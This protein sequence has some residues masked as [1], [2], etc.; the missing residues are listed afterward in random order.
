M[1]RRRGGTGQDRDKSV[2]TTPC[3]LSPAAGHPRG[4]CGARHHT[5]ATSTSTSISTPI[6]ISISTERDGITASPG[7]SVLPLISRPGHGPELPRVFKIASFGKNEIYLLEPFSSQSVRLADVAPDNLQLHF[8]LLLVS[9]VARELCV[10]TRRGQDPKKERGPK[11]ATNTP[12]S[13]HPPYI[14]TQHTDTS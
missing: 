13:P 4:V 9:H 11:Q 1:S 8:S 14:H 12:Q 10:L 7:L 3:L 2:N 6:S 5:R